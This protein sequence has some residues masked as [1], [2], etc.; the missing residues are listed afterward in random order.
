MH[1]S[2]IVFNTAMLFSLH[3]LSQASWCVGIKESW[4]ANRFG[5]VR[6]WS[7]I[8]KEF[9][10]DREIEIDPSGVGHG[11]DSLCGANFDGIGTLQCTGD[12]RAKCQ[13]NVATLDGFKCRTHCDGDKDCGNSGLPI[14]PTQGFSTSADLICDQR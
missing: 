3:G 12:V 9:G 7:K 4:D 11:I 10:S 14:F 13:A 1:F 8:A 2:K 6:Q 5:T